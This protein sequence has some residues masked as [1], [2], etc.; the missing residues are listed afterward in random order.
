MDFKGENTQCEGGGVSITSANN[1]V[2]VNPSPLIAA[3]TIGL[4]ADLQYNDTTKCLTL[5]KNNS[6][7]D[8]SA[9]HNILIGDNAGSAITSADDNILIGH[10]VARYDEQGNRNVCIGSNAGVYN[11]GGN[12]TY[13]GYAA[14]LAANSG[15]ANYNTAIGSEALY[16]NNSRS[17]VAI[18][19]QAV[20][21]NVSGDNIVGI[22]TGA[23][24]KVGY[25]NASPSG[26]LI[27]IGTNCIKDVTECVNSVVIGHENLNG[28]SLL[29]N[30]I[31]Y[32]NYN[33]NAQT[34]EYV[35]DDCVVVGNNNFSAQSDC[36]EF[37]HNGAIVIGNGGSNNI[38]MGNGKQNLILIGNNIPIT[39]GMLSE[40]SL[41]AGNYHAM[42]A[43][44][45]VYN[46][47]SQGINALRSK[48]AVNGGIPVDNFTGL[49]CLNWNWSAYAYLTTVTP[50]VLFDVN[51][52]QIKWDTPAIQNDPSGK[53]VLFTIEFTC[54]ATDDTRTALS[55]FGG[56]VSFMV[57]K[58]VGSWVFSSLSTVDNLTLNAGNRGFYNFSPGTNFNGIYVYQPSYGSPEI[59]VGVVWNSVANEPLLNA[60][61]S[62][63]V[64][65][66][67]ATNLVDGPAVPFVTPS[68]DSAY[69]LSHA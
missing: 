31:M 67:L 15:I 29:N 32:G 10:N 66:V 25:D 47:E 53:S 4:V 44:S 17:I 28:V 38:P 57:F 60:T 6:M 37:E 21:N 5:G 14:G 51:M 34:N 33:L 58:N 11:V 64:R 8:G 20:R 18:G 45:P 36:P 54:N 24:F 16:H 68:V 2:V 23:L 30:M 22:G 19:Y 55:V 61:V 12:N 50:T 41:L 3:G 48:A 13:I 39:T 65:A 52:E 69:I 43:F 9:L 49:K 56:S 42:G 7:G 1:G 62:T 40:T 27:G 35:A 59:Q 26:S 46:F 63:N